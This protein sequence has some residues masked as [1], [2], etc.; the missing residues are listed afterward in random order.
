MP[1]VDTTK[2]IAG[3][4]GTNLLPRAVSSEIWR[5]ATA[6]SIVPD[7][8]TTSPIIL[9]DNVFPEV[10]KRPAATIV[11]EGA[12]KKDSQ[13]ELGAKSIRPIK[14]Q[15]GL[16]FTL[17]AITANPVGVLGLLQEE[18]SSALARQIDLAVLHKKVADS[19]SAITTGGDIALDTVQAVELGDANAV[20]SDI[21]TGYGLVTT[22]GYD[23]TGFGFDPKFIARLRQAVNP[24]N[25]Q[26]Y[27]PEL[28]FGT[29]VTNFG[30]LTA[31]VSKTVSG[32]VDA[33]T[34]TNIRAVAGDFNAL[35]FGYAL[36]IPVKKIEF[37]DPFGNGDLQRRNTVAYLAEVIFGWAVM[38]PT[39]FVV[40]KEKAAEVPAK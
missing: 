9:G 36:N 31:R 4:G 13:M 19:G 10:T 26:K 8:A 30:G 1:T 18:L 37:G 25:G 39:A 3:E 17:E 22:A 27:H 16:E 34:D 28:G 12:N 38:D 21:E 32:Q 15:V 11:G 14:A 35:K 20:D 2:L 23:F 7:L 33:V 29:Q 5:K 24:K 6:A 40:F